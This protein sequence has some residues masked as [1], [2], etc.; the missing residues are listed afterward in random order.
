M[1]DVNNFTQ[2]LQISMIMN[3]ITANIQFLRKPHAYQ[4]V[5]AS[6]VTSNRIISKYKFL[7]NTLSQC[8][9]SGQLTY[10]EGLLSCYF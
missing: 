4:L 5:M 2:I 8:K 6:Y 9:T 1:Y 10:K 7:F 3:L